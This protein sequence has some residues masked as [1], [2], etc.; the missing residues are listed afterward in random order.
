MRSRLRSFGISAFALCLALG[1]VDVAAEPVTPDED[2]LF[3]FSWMFRDGDEMRPRGGTTPGPELEIVKHPLPAWHALQAAGLTKKERDR[4]AIVAM[5][6]SFRASFEFLE[7]VGFAADF[8]P[9]RPYQSW[10]TEHVYVVADEEDFIS[11]QHIMVI[12][13]AGADGRLSEPMVMK[14]WRQDWRFEDRALLGYV[15]H[16]T[17]QGRALDAEA[18]RGTWSQAV[19]Q[20]DDSPRYESTGRWTHEPHAS[21]WTGSTTRRPL[22]RRESSVRDDYHT[23][24]GT[25]RHT[26]VPTGWIHEQDNLKVALE[27]A[28]TDGSFAP[29]SVLA[30]EIG[31]NRYEAIAGYDFSAGDAYW[32]STGD[33]WQAVRASWDHIARTQRRFTLRPQ[34]GGSPLFVSMFQGAGAHADNPDLEVDQDAID[35]TIASFLVE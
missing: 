14:H 7:T 22:P 18:V 9:H 8:E 20:V 6:G 4:R 16:R 33:Y 11:L 23:L 26:I 2:R 30:R 5:A 12:R 28:N 10:T 25:N 34:V 19:F 31:L 24:E 1:G 35:Q 32:A 27:S 13:V 3:T 29:R 17:W 21:I 15:G